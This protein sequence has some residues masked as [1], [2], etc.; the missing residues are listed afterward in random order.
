MKSVSRQNI[1]KN[2]GSFVKIYS[3]FNEPALKLFS[4]LQHIF[5][6][7]LCFLHFAAENVVFDGFSIYLI[8]CQ[9]AQVTSSPCKNFCPIIVVDLP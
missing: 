6:K 2:H 3:P 9:A 7:S 5:L 8:D 4:E 1:N